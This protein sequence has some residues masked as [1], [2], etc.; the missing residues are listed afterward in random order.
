[1]PALHETL[2]R[3]L[4]APREAGTTGAAAARDLVA[5]YLEA[6]GY[7]V[8]RQRFRFAPSAPLGLPVF[9]AGL[10]ALGLLLLPAL[11]GDTLPG[12]TALLLLG[13]GLAVLTMLAISVGL[14]WI[15]IGGAARE[16]ANLIATRG[17]GPVR[18]WIVAHLDTKAQAH[19]MAGRLVAIWL[20]ILSIAVLIGLV[21]ARLGGPLPLVVAAVGAVLAV[22]A[23]S[24]AGGGRLR[25]GSP[26]ARD[27]GTGLAGALA[28]GEALRGS[29]TG[30][31]ITGAEEFGLV[32]A[33]I[34]VADRYGMIAGSVIVN[35]DTIDQE[36]QLALVTHDARG[37]ALAREVAPGLAPVGLPSRIRRL[38]LG[39][40]TD[41]VPFARR[42]IPALTIGRLTWRTLRLIH[43][44]ADTADG[45]SLDAAIRIGRALAAN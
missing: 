32:G 35:L 41:S 17:S 4:A 31:L 3:L 11:T 39:I 42:G 28:A 44:P 25:S 33:R 7:Q 22:I 36:G 29:D 43:T 15:P 13:G 19:S 34:F 20:L 18:R 12:W 1:V 27:N 26:G 24:L 16:D 37:T 14:G 23:G 8:E 5:A 30:I 45:L 2:E 21:F 6:L 38:P 9:G 40:L 10:G